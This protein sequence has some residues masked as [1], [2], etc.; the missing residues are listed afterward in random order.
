MLELD[1]ATGAMICPKCGI[2]D[3]AEEEKA[4]DVEEATTAESTPSEEELAAEEEAAK[5]EADAKAKA[6]EAA[7]KER[8]ALEKKERREQRR[9]SR[10]PL[11]Y[12]LGIAGSVSCFIGRNSFILALICVF[13]NVLFAFIGYN[14]G[15][16]INFDL[17]IF[18]MSSVAS[19]QIIVITGLKRGFYKAEKVG[20]RI[21]VNILILV[22]CAVL[23]GLWLYEGAYDPLRYVL[24]FAPL[25]LVAL[26]A[27]ILT[28]YG[29]HWNFP[30]VPGAMLIPVCLVICIL[31]ARFIPEEYGT[32]LAASILHCI[33]AG[34]YFASIAFRDH[35]LYGYRLAGQAKAYYHDHVANTGEWGIVHLIETVGGIFVLLR[36][37][38]SLNIF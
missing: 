9:Q 27:H 21:L 36:I 31:T 35:Y 26:L 24:A 2:P 16:D 23:M 3:G 19:L 22:A 8:R 37:C 14:N 15:S 38:T 7:E 29:T 34:I 4:A 20:W 25:L 1:E 12:Y 32:V 33:I 10:K 6:E 11:S 28:T 5:A 18:I 17:F 30:Y 13:C